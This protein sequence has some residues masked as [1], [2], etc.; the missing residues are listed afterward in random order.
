MA[1]ELHDIEPAWRAW[2]D[3][4]RPVW[5]FDPHRLRGVYANAAARDLWGASS[6]AELLGRDYSQLSPAVRARTERLALATADGGT[7]S[8]RWTF[9]PRGAPVTVEA[10][11]STYRLPDGSP[12]LLFEA[13]PSDAEPEERRALE[14]LRHTDAA[15]SLFTPDGQNLFSNPAAFDAYG[16]SDLP[17]AERFIDPEAPGRLLAAALDTGVD[18][19]IHA[20]ETRAGRRWRRMAAHA[21]LDPV[22]G[23]PSVLLNE[24]DVTGEMEARE[25]QAEAERR[26]AA[27]E[28][29]QALLSTLSHELRTPLNAVLGFSSL[30][31]GESLA[32]E[33]AD[34]VARI[35]AAGA[36]LLD[37]VNEIIDLADG[38][39]PGHA[40]QTVLADGGPAGAAGAGAPPAGGAEPGPPRVLYV[41]DHPANR[42]LVEALLGALGAPCTLAED[43][44]RGV[45]AAA[46][47]DWDLIL[48]DIQMPVMDGVEATRAIRALPG[49][50]G[51]VPIVALT[52]NTLAAERETYTRAGMN[53]C[54][55]KP[56][57]LAALAACLETWGRR[58]EGLEQ[59][60]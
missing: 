3:L 49:R 10:T 7:V 50:A 54:L 31:S 1:S 41:E 40:P 53:A 13:S 60:A 48:M 43:G 56:V 8:E 32:P 5:L 27:A 15:I 19:E 18:G 35:H 37:V 36:R 2:E 30:L 29:R 11:I 55:A 38:G 9:Y 6:L 16:R 22:T 57:D 59:A 17:F 52:A 26:S 23:A 58:G 44:V 20:V 33:Q 4:R 28:A 21:G 24:T 46:A 51:A 14:A 34:K 42:A 39:A 47:G 25:A 12:V 45:E